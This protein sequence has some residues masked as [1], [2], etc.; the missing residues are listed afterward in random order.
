MIIVEIFTE[1]SGFGSNIHP[2][3]YLSS[4]LTSISLTTNIPWNPSRCQDIFISSGGIWYNRA[5]VKLDEVITHLTNY[6]RLFRCAYIFG[7]VVRGEED[8]Y[9]DV[10]LII[11]RETALP[12]LERV[13]EI[14]ELVL[15]LGGAECLIYTESEFEKMK[16]TSGFIQE[17]LPEAVKVEGQQ[18]RSGPVVE[19]GGK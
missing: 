19:T 10:D 14:T 6:S 18:K 17:V 15:A 9:S 2:P 1:D 16:K 3:L 7:S 5:V 12:F 8:E 13:R 11:I 4:W